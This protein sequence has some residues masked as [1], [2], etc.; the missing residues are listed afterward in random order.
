VL[1]NTSFVIRHRLTPRMA[2]STGCGPIVS[3]HRPHGLPRVTIT[4]QQ[5]RKRRRSSAMSARC[6][7]L[8]S[9]GTLLCTA[10]HSDMSSPTIAPASLLRTSRRPALRRRAGRRPARAP[11]ERV[12]LSTD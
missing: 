10:T 8:D 7:Q 9:I 12:Y 5:P 2:C 3:G 4:T 1:R 11:P 6:T